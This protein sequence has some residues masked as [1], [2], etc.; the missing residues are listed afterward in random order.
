VTAFIDSSNA[1]LGSFAD[2]EASIRAA[3]RELPPTLQETKGALKSSNQ[4]AIQAAPAIRDSLPGARALAPALRALRPL[5]TETVAP[6][7]D[8]I[9]PFTKQ[10]A[11]PVHHLSQTSVNLGKTVPPLRLSLTRLNEIFNAL[12]ANPEGSA[13][14]YLFYVPWLNHNT[15]NMYTLQ[16]AHGPIRRAALMASCNTS[17]LA[18]ASVFTTKP[19]IATLAELTQF[20]LPADIC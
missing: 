2:Q 9:R 4:F 19:Y 14:G 16:D 10:V 7:R 6:I 8:Q 20:P 15:S 11:G 3:L 13:E 1:V 18:A 12:A 5:F 17:R